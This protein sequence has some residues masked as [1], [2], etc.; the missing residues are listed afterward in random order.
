M[1][2]FFGVR[3]AFGGCFISPSSIHPQHPSLPPSLLRIHTTQYT[4]T[5]PTNSSMSRP[6]G[7]LWQGSDDDSSAS[8]TEAA[9]DVG[10]MEKRQQKRWEVDSDSGTCDGCSKREG[11]RGGRGG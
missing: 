9:V 8:E 2:A 3:A 11:R 6:G 10:G 4:E 7:K 5:T 1:P